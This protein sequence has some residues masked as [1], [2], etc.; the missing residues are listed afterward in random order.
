[1]RFDGSAEFL[2][3]RDYV[4]ITSIDAVHIAKRGAAFGGEHRDED[5]GR[6]A[7]RRRAYNFCSP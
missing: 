7:K 2:E 1:M 4:F 5:D 6:G 3:A